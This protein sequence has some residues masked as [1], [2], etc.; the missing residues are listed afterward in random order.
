M[1]NYI[2]KSII[3]H[4]NQNIFYNNNLYNNNINLKGK[5]FLEKN[6]DYIH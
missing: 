6:E 2:E 4:I 5:F 3:N 1:N